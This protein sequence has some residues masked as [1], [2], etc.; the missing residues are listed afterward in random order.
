SASR[1]IC[2]CLISLEFRRVCDPV[3]TRT[4]VHKIDAEWISGI[5]TVSHPVCLGGDPAQLPCHGQEQDALQFG[6]ET[7]SRGIAVCISR[8]SKLNEFE[9]ATLRQHGLLLS[10]RAGQL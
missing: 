4:Q 1:G 3:R 7:S 9:A 10:E 5:D 8:R 2:G 6:G